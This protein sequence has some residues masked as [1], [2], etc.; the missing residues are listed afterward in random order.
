MNG[1]AEL[2]QYFFINYYPQKKKTK[3][4]I[5]TNFKF[6]NIVPFALFYLIFYPYPVGG[7]YLPFARFHQC[8]V[9]TTFMFL[10]VRTFLSLDFISAPFILHLCFWWPVPSLSLDFIRITHTRNKTPKPK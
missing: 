10:V 1:Q 7:L 5:S 9:C 4:T 3:S 2:L 6:I 8:S